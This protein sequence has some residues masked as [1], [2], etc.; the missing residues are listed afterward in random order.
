MEDRPRLKEFFLA[1]SG[2][3]G[4]CLEVWYVWYQKKC[5]K[6]PR[7]FSTLWTISLLWFSCTC[8]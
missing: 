4:P 7:D 8:I 3:E 2:Q 6:A 5:R 1:I